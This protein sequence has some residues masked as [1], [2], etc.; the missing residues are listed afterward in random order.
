MIDGKPYRLLKRHLAT[1]GLTPAGYRERFGLRHDYPMV[2]PAY[3]AIRSTLA[4]QSDLG[5]KRGEVVK[6]AAIGNEVK[7]KALDQYV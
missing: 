2:A 6:K 3:T 4:K 1:N 5:R 7:G